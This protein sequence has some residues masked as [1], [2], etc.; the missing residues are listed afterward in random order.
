MQESKSRSHPTAW[1]V[2]YRVWVVA[3]WALTVLALAPR[4]ARVDRFLAVAPP[5]GGEAVVADAELAAP[6][7]SPVVHY[8]IPIVGCG[9]QPLSAPSRA[10]LDSILPCLSC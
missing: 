4:A 9:P 10:L 5:V 3:G 1:V 7:V 8:V 2:R 6:F